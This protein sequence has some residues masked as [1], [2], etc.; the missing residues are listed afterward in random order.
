MKIVTEANNVNLSK[1]QCKVDLY[2][3]DM[4]LLINCHFLISVRSLIE[5]NICLIVMSISI[6]CEAP[7]RE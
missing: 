6:M 3:N 5:C 1:S 4:E 7:G 2:W